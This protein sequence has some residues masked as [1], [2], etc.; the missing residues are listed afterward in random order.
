MGRQKALLD[1]PGYCSIALQ[2][3]PGFLGWQVHMLTHFAIQQTSL[4]QEHHDLLECKM[5]IKNIIFYNTTLNDKRSNS[6]KKGIIH[7][8]DPGEKRKTPS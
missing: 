3:L 2:L 4:I 5:N 6:L 1:H 8:F 7:K